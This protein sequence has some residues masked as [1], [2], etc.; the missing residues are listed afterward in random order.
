MLSRLIVAAALLGYLS[1]ICDEAYQQAPTI[2]NELVNRSSISTAAAGARRRL[3]ERI[4]AHASE[5][6]LGM[7][8]SK[9]PPEMSI[10]FSLLQTGG[11]HRKGTDGFSI[12]LPG[13]KT[14]KCNLR[15]SLE[16]I[17]DIVKENK[18][19]RVPISD[20]FSKLRLK[21]YGVRAGVLPIFLAVFAKLYEQD[22]AFYENG[23]F[24][25]QVS[26]DD[27]QRIIK[28]PDTFDI[29]YCKVSGVRTD[30]FNKL[31]KVLGLKATG[32]RN[33]ELLDVVRPLCV[34]VAQLSEYTH[35]TKKLSNKTISVRS[36]LM[37]AREPST[38]LFS[39]LP[40]ACGL[41]PFYANKK[42]DISN[43]NEFVEALKSSLEELKTA[44]L[45]LHERMK[46]VINEASGM[47]GSFND[48]RGTLSDISEK[49]LIYIKEPRLKGFCMRL[50]DK[51]LPEQEW[52]ESLGSFVCSKPPSKWID[53]DEDLFEYEAKQLF[54][55]FLRVESLAFDIE[56]ESF[57]GSAVRVTVT[58]ADGTEVDHVLHVSK[59]EEQM[60]SKVETEVSNILKKSKRVGLA[61][62]F[63][64]YLERLKTRRRIKL[65]KVFLYGLQS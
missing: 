18:D 38:L 36:A 42:T 25:R 32:K 50:S 45:E 46:T 63:K 22:L 55:R 1:D 4:Y 16:R 39:D 10:Y 48:V 19:A 43:S 11:L 57:D 14:D 13:K 64:V 7:D 20:I 58:K 3:I 56:N 59:E 53:S 8:S 17:L 54:S 61:G 40:K 21:P 31:V 47:P 24:M 51:N 49:V 41:K 44:Y 6:L 12:V 26:G 5:P 65:R 52:L 30:V 33:T 28:A 2:R 27:Y 62:C 35:K 29:Q 60:V 15:P 9:K 37:K 34:F 23:S